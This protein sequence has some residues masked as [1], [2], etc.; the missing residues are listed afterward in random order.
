MVF[1]VGGGCVIRGARERAC[2]TRTLLHMLERSVLMQ[3]K[4]ATCLFRTAQ[5]TTSDSVPSGISDVRTEFLFGS[6]FTAEGEQLR[7]APP[8]RW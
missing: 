8:H 2:R 3:K 6:L 1:R 7:T 5:V 4:R